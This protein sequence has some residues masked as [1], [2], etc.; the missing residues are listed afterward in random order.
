[1]KK[2]GLKLA[3]K[4]DDLRKKSYDRVPW[5]NF[6]TDATKNLANDQAIDFLDRCLRYDHQERLTAAEAM[7]HPYFDPVRDHTTF[8][9]HLA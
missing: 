7:A 1:M 8:P 5:T 6:V 2:Y 3:K 4:Y 9:S